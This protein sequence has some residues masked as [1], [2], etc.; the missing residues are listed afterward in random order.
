MFYFDHSAAD[1]AVTFFRRFLRHAKGELAGQPFELAQWQADEIIRPLFGWKLTADG[2]RKY[3]TAYIEVGRGAGKTT[4]AAGIALYLLL[5]D[6]EKGGECYAAACD[7]SQAA[8][9]FD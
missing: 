2:T 3:R 1:R 6:S 9:T 4:L 5:A 8:L 7:R